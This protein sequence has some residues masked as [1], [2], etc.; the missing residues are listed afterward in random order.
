MPLTTATSTTVL[1]FFPTHRKN[2]ANE[3]PKGSFGTY[4]RELLAAQRSLQESLEAAPDIFIRY[5]QP[6]LLDASRAIL[7]SL[8][9][10]PVAETVLVKNAT[11]GVNT[12]LHNLVFT[13]T[14]SPNDVIIYFETAYG[15][16]ERALLALRE[17]LDVK[18]RK[19]KYIF[20]LGEGEMVRKFRGVIESVRQE[21]LT[22]KL[23]VF[24]TV[25][26]NPGIRFPFE[27]VTRVCREEG[28]LSLIDGAHGVGMIDLD[29][30][31][32]GADFFTSNCHKYVL[33]LTFLCFLVFPGFGDLALNRCS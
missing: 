12:V 16:V 8:L 18:L 22:P 23:A 4:P 17:S 29:L 14:L 2:S 15:A 7:A 33:L 10:V 6:P 25:V 31:R 19:V 30:G 13:H 27:D 24:E 5:T 20:P 28:V 3:E 9:K 1:S 32:L 11:T 21:G 26:S